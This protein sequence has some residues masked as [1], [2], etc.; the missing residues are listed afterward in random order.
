MIIAQV[1]L[2][3][4]KKQTR[5]SD[6]FIIL[7]AISRATVGLFLYIFF[8]LNPPSDLEY[9]DVLILQFAGILL[10]VDIDYNAV[11]KVIRKKYPKFLDSIY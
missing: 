9:G 2:I 4:F 8:L 10:L 11:V 6:T 1:I 7:D 3:F 5:S